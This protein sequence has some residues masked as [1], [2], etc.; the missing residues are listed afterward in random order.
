MRIGTVD[1][2]DRGNFTALRL[3][4]EDQIRM[5]LPVTLKEVDFFND[6]MVKMT[7]FVCSAAG[8]CQVDSKIVE[9]TENDAKFGLICNA[10]HCPLEIGPCGTATEPINS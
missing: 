8:Q 3:T 6:S 7:K 9:G 1:I 10:S 4:S 5:A 2:T